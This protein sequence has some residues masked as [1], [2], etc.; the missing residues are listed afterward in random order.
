MTLEGLSRIL[1]LKAGRRF[2]SSCLGKAVVRLYIAPVLEALEKEIQTLGP[3]LEKCWRMCHCLSLRCSLKPFVFERIGLNVSR[4][5]LE[6]IPIS[7]EK[8]ELRRLFSVF[9]GQP[10]AAPA[11]TLGRSR[12][13][14]AVEATKPRKDSQRI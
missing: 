3:F 13:G 6:R 12:N 14:T 4:Q 1:F 2:V 11:P 8:A 5:R 10:K 7:T 9:C